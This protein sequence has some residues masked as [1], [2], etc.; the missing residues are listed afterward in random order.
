MRTVLITGG[1][2]LLGKSLIKHFA[3]LGDKVIATDIKP[4]T[5]E[6]NNVRCVKMS[7]I[8]PKH[9]EEV[10]K[11]D[12][13]NVLI[14]NA[15]VNKTTYDNIMNVNCKGTY[16][17]CRE[18]IEQ[19]VKTI[20][21]IASIYGI[22]SPNPKVSNNPCTYGMSKAAI[23]QMTKYL[24]THHKGVRVNCVSPGGIYDNQDVNFVMGYNSQVPMKRM[25]TADE[26]AKVIVFLASDD[27]S[28]INGENI[29]IDG[30]LTIW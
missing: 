16:F 27:A 29:I 18:A 25:A 26:I 12:R 15:G 22:V 1:A 6:F 20:V 9:I 23:I 10:F 21:N 7:V 3:R 19:G 14:N 2:G 24:A 4:F 8:E 11:S 28:Y 13:I 5:S 17:C 30:G